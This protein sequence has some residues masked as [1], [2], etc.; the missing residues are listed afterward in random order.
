VNLQLA[1][2]A[3]YALLQVL[4]GLWMGRKVKDTGDFFVA[5][6]RLG[7]GLLFSTLVAANIGAGSTVGATGLG[8]RDGLGAWWWVGSAGIGSLI[9]ALW[10]GPRIR[11]IA[12][13]KGLHTVGDYLELRYSRG[14]RGGVV[15]LLWAATLTVLAGQLVAAGVILNV[16]AGL[17]TWAGSVIGGIVM[18]MYFTAGGLMGAAWVHAFQLVVEVGVYCVLLPVAISGAGG[19]ASVVARAP[20]T[21]TYWDFTSGWV[22]L[23]LLA[24]AFI[25]SPGQLQKVYGA[26]DDRAVRWGVGLNAGLLLLFACVPPVLG[27]VA[28]ALHPALPDHQLALPTLLMHDLPPLLGAIG[29]AAAFTTDV[30]TADAV[31]FMLSTSMAQDLYK[32]F[33]NP[34]ASDAQV[35]RVARLAALAGGVLGVAFAVSAPSVIGNL[36][37]FY[38]LLS[39]CLFVPIL[40]GLF[41]PR[42]RTLEAVAAIATGVALTLY[43]QAATGGRGY[44]LLSPALLGIGSGVV[45]CAAATLAR[46]A[47]RASRH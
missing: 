10:V 33:L 6:R 16:V 26:K 41:V 44:G 18:T 46:G 22:Y 9:L 7:P 36:T 8:Y 15:L 2:L 20:A 28:R 12:A 27:I 38:T 23:V 40:A 37:I 32:G 34:R 19:W 4:L 24:P 29:L 35:L 45:A 17:P 25:V 42:V 13:E 47:P 1:V 21:A 43:V 5:G 14:V 30:N 11:R 39:V 3:G 31:L